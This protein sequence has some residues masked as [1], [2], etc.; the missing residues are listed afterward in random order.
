[1]EEKERVGGKTEGKK[2]RTVTF[3]RCPSCII[4]DTFRQIDQPR[5]TCEIHI[6]F[7]FHFETPRLD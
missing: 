2:T 4:L 6:Q 1:M 7:I 5:P 3:S